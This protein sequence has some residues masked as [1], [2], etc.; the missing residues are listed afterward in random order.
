M[1]RRRTP[2][3][4]I[5][6][7]RSFIWPERGFRRLF[8]YFFQRIVRMPGTSGSIAAGMATSPGSLSTSQSSAYCMAHTKSYT[9]A[10]SS[11]RGSSGRSTRWGRIRL[12]AWGTLESSPRSNSRQRPKETTPPQDQLSIDGT[13]RPAAKAR[14]HKTM[15]LPTCSSRPT[16]PGRGPS[17][18]PAPRAC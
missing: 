16:A 8:A 15:I 10:S 7:I 3:T 5:N 6:Q 9:S 1:F 14:R 2:L 11:A 13:K 12:P 18:R 4:K 17:T